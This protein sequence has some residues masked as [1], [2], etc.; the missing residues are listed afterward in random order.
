MSGQRHVT[1]RARKGSA[2]PRAVRRAVTCPSE[3]GWQHGRRTVL[4]SDFR[5]LWGAA[6]SPHRD[7]E[8]RGQGRAICKSCHL[9]GP[10]RVESEGK[11]RWT[12]QKGAFRLTETKEEKTFWKL[13]C[14][15][16]YRVSPCSHVLL[17]LIEKKPVSM[18][19]S[20]LAVVTELAM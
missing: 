1:G 11:M 5:S 15:V 16:C 8:H 10:P 18:G 6:E 4:S 3:K 2:G 9:C 19:L 12:F 13:L 7:N 14:A 20:R 17:I